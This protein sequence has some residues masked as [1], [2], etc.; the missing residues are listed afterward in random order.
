QVTEVLTEVAPLFSSRHLLI[1]IAAGISL[2]RLAEFLGQEA[3][4]IRVMPNTPALV[5]AGAAAHAAS[6]AATAQDVQLVDRL[7]NAVGRAFPLP[8]KLLD[9]VTGLSSSGPAFVY[10]LIEA[11][12][13]GG[14]L[15]GLPR[16]VATEL[17]AQTVLGSARMVLE[18]GQHPGQLKDMV[19]S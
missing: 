15:M 8:E 7:L 3:R 5:G 10:V 1:S 19:A 18:T 17:A 2:A 4:L 12:S 9:A 6:P 13:D 11:L 14:V 16:T